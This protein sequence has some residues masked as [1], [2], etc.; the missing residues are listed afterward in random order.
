MALESR[1]VRVAFLVSVGVLPG[2]AHAHAGH[3]VAGGES[4]VHLLVDHG[5]VVVLGVVA[6]AGG[7]LLLRALRSAG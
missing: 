4:F 6:L 5:F 7:A 2:I 1:S 3:G